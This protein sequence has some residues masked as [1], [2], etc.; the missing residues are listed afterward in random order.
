M[1]LKRLKIN[2]LQLTKRAK[3]YTIKV[4]VT[5]GQTD[6]KYGKASLLKSFKI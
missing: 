4:T 2:I 5:D 3:C 1:L 6:H